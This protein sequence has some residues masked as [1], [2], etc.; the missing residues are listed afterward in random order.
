MSNRIAEK[1]RKKTKKE[2]AGRRKV[3]K[4]M[5]SLMGLPVHAITLEYPDISTS[6]LEV[7]FDILT[8]KV[9]GQN[10]LHEWSLGPFNSPSDLQW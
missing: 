10:I 5:K 8:G 2:E 7:I 3:E 6:D 1:E 4:T 9:V